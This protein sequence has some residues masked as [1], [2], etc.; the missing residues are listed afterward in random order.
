MKR[1]INLA[2]SCVVALMTA[3]AFVACDTT[4]RLE[5]TVEEVSAE[6]PIVLSEYAEFTS[7]K[8]IDGNVQMVMTVDDDLVD[9]KAI[10]ANKPLVKQ[11]L[12]MAF[13]NPDSSTQQLMKLLKDEGAD[14]IVIYKG[15]NSG[16]SVKVVISADEL[17]ETDT[18]NYDAEENLQMQIE[19]ANA[20][21]PN[22]LAD[23]LVMDRVYTEGKHVVYHYLTDDNE[24]DIDLLNDNIDELKKE[25]LNELKHDQAVVRFLENVRE[26]NMDVRYVYE[27]Y[28]TGDQAYFTIKPSEVLR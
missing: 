1:I 9:L 7:L 27:S 8:Y 19:L 11:Q 14:L 24:I 20:Q 18:D 5:K 15:R 26:L 28:Q 10:K 6:L 22:E 23:G 16:K 12:I 13:S 25:T 4:P 17:D 2:L 21:C 3:L